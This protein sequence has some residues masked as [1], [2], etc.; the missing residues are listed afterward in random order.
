VTFDPTNP[1]SKTVVAASAESG[2][3]NVEDLLRI[4]FGGESDLPGAVVSFIGRIVEQ[5]QAERET[6]LAALRVY[7]EE[8]TRLTLEVSQARGE[9]SQQLRLAREEREHLVSEFLDRVD[10]LSAK[11]S[12]TASKYEGELEEKDAKIEDQERRVEAYA[13]LAADAQS[14]LG[15]MRRSSSWR[16][17]AP[18]RL[19][20]RLMASRRAP[21]DS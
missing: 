8:T 12:T 18:F 3:G 13:G 1:S 5:Q 2:R 19:F 20:S 10:Q 14:E 6:F 7:K 9:L 16:L 15:A 4:E 17:T 11:I 21:S